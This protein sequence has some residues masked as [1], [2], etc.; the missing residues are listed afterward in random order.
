MASSTTPGHVSVSSVRYWPFFHRLINWPTEMPRTRLARESTIS[1]N[2]SLLIQRTC[3]LFFFFRA[4]GIAF[5]SGY[6]T[7]FPLLYPHWIPGSW[8]LSSVC[9]SEKDQR[10]DYFRLHF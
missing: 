10:A 9:R 7:E 6:G 8:K 3:A 4:V 2:S 5:P 1:E